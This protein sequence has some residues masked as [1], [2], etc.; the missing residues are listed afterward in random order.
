[1]SLIAWDSNSAANRLKQFGIITQPALIKLKE[2]G[3]N[4]TEWSEEV[5]NHLNIMGM[6]NILTFGP[7]VAG[8]L[9]P[10]HNLFPV[11]LFF[12]G[13]YRAITLEQIKAVTDT[14]YNR[15]AA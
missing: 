1:M 14:H 15:L 11:L 13:K 5:I 6:S 4:F 12:F 7:P 10:V 8:S 3:S 9:H 2:N